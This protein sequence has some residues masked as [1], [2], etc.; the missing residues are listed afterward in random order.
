MCECLYSKFDIEVI[1]QKYE[2]Y[3]L[4]RMFK[5]I[6]TKLLKKILNIN[7]YTKRK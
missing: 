5:R 3:I 6:S 2:H 4:K 7:T 1:L